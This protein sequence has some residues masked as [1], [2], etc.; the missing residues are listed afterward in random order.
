MNDTAKLALFVGTG[1]AVGKATNSS[2]AYWWMLGG[3]G[4]LFILSSPGIKG[5]IS[6]GAGAAHSK[7]APA[8][9]K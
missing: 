8:W 3:L 6:K 5:A 4:A 1:M 2:S 7:Y 9:A